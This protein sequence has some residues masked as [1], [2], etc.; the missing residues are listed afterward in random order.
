MR[1]PRIL[2]CS[3]ILSLAG[4]SVGY[5][6]ELRQVDTLVANQDLASA[7]ELLDSI[8]E[9]LGESQ[10]AL[11]FN[12]GRA[13]LNADEAS[14]AI[15]HFRR[16]TG[17]DDAIGP[18]AFL[19]IGNAHAK[20][21]QMNLQA[22]QL[23]EAVEA[24]EAAIEAYRS[25]IELENQLIE[26]EKLRESDRLEALEH[27]LNVVKLIYKIIL[28]ALQDQPESPLE[29]ILREL[30]R[31]IANHQVQIQESISLLPEDLPANIDPLLPAEM[32]P[33][34]KP[35]WMPAA[36]T[37]G[38]DDYKLPNPPTTPEQVADMEELALENILTI[39]GM[40]TDVL[41]QVEGSAQATIDQIQQANPASGV[42]DETRARLLQEEKDLVD[43]L[44]GASELLVEAYE[45]S[46]LAEEGW[47]GDGGLAALNNSM[48]SRD[49][50]VEAYLHLLEQQ[51][52]EQSQSGQEGNE[53]TGEPAQNGE[54]ATGSESEEDAE[55]SSGSASD[56]Q[57]TDSTAENQAIRNKEDAQ[58]ALQDYQDQVQAYRD[59]QPN[60]QRGGGRGPV[61]NDW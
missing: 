41:N 27:N 29:A 58:Q 49:G 39:D 50:Q 37:E 11:D 23:R 55:G 16:A 54:T 1:R 18:K 17:S 61:I 53:S 5:D 60:D 59:E 32:P 34:S 47:R 14:Q 56:G 57:Q 13:A 51:Q 38:D 40:I 3:L 28:N 33:E 21:G 10:A 52:Q 30:R 42:D 20:L 48:S 22:A 43:S 19:G 35:Q 8:E 7:N 45:S 4:C 26:E 12:R 6:D 15:D 24:Y 25:G 36:L 31:T 9:E 2:A 46:E 44:V